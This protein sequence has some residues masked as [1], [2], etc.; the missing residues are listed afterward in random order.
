[1]WPNGIGYRKDSGDLDNEMLHLPLTWD[2]MAE[3]F[4]IEAMDTNNG[5]VTRGL[6]LHVRD[7]TA[8]GPLHFRLWG[9]V[10]ECAMGAT[11]NWDG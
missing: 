11:G 9:F 8:P 7:S 5:D 3:R 10:K 1:M 2:G 6:S 4:Q